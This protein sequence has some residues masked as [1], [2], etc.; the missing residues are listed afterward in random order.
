[1]KAARIMAQAKLRFLALFRQAA[2][3]HY[4]GTRC[5]PQPIEERYE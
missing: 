5:R 4:V 2:A 1:M 3:L